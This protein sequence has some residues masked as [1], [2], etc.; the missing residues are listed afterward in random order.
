VSGPL[1]LALAVGGDIWLAG[2]GGVYRAAR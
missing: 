2:E 1:H